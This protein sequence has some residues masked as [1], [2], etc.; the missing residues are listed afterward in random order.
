MAVF[1]YLACATLLSRRGE[2]GATE[3]LGDALSPKR[4]RRRQAPSEPSTTAPVPRPAH[5]RHIL[6]LRRPG[7]PAATPSPPVSVAETGPAP[8]PQ[9]TCP[10]VS[11]M[12]VSTGLAVTDA[13]T[14]VSWA[15]AVTTAEA[16]GDLVHNPAATP[17]W[18]R[19][20]LSF[21]HIATA[22]RPHWREGIEVCRRMA[23]RLFDTFDTQ[24]ASV[25]E[26]EQCLYGMVFSR[27][28]LAS[29]VVD[30]LE[31]CLAESGA[32]PRTILTDLL[33]RLRPMSKP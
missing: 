10:P 27:A 22:L 20:A 9:T 31:S 14:A 13:D 33:A 2:G 8:Q 24:G 12:P 5:P 25:Q 16:T 11:V 7:T 29:H 15:V 4:H 19:E 3:G 30:W 21:W 28:N 26:L 1:R 32:D 18:A 17:V 6:L 23:Q